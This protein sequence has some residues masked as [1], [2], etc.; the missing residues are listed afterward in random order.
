MFMKKFIASVTALVII[1]TISGCGG[2]GGSGDSP[3][4][5]MMSD[6]EPLAS[7]TSSCAAPDFN[8][9]FV[10]TDNA[11]EF[12]VFSPDMD[13][14]AV[15]VYS[16]GEVVY[17]IVSDGRTIFGFIGA[18][19]DNGS[20][21]ALISAS[22]DYDGDGVFDETATNFM[23]NSTRLEDGTGILLL[24]GPSSVDASQAFQD[25]LLNLYNQILF[26]NFL[27]PI[28]CSG[29]EAVSSSGIYEILLTELQSQAG[30]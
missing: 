6:R 18:P 8:T 24:N 14:L 22:E 17:F 11:P 1:L 5:Q 3:E 10:N 12:L 29:V 20:S 7:I 30:A 16:D 2:S 23:S 27:S 13:T 4:N 25:N 15:R 28:G 26:Y 9:P 21:G 19:L